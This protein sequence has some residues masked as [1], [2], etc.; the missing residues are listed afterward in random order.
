M[1][2]ETA[3]FHACPRWLLCGISAL[4]QRRGVVPAQSQSEDIEDPG[5]RMPEQQIP[6]ANLKLT[7]FFCHTR[8]LGDHTTCGNKNDIIAQDL[9]KRG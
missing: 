5:K 6:A 9:P 4:P 1:N 7:V 3:P 8:N 2:Q